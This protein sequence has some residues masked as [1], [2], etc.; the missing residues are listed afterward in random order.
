[1]SYT[2]SIAIIGT[3]DASTAGKEKA[4]EFASVL[5][6]GGYV[7]IS[8]YAKGIDTSAHYGAVNNQGKTIAVLPT[9][10][11][12]FSIHEELA[13]TSEQ[14]LDKA[15]ILSEFF[16]LAEWS[17]GNALTRNRIT[18]VLADKLL[19]I[20]AGDSGGTFNTCEYAKEQG[21]PIF[22]Y[23]GIP[24][25]MDEKIIKLG[26]ISIKSPEEINHNHELHE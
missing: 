23:N 10:I 16:P 20:D 3:R 14:F 17:V 4:F 7:I 13:N 2:K 1:L 9:G 11:L 21:K 25:P 15:T 24:S 8:G 12:K 6:K 22:I 26:A 18:S 5:S 19:V